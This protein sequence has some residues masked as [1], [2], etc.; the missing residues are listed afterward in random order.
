VLDQDTD[1]KTKIFTPADFVD[2]S[3]LRPIGQT[4]L[5]EN[6]TANEFVPKRATAACLIDGTGIIR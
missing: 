4:G 3:F 1:P 2:L 5:V 6:Y